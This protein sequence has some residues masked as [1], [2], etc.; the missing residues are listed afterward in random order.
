ML[1][2]TSPYWPIENNIKLR[3]NLVAP[4]L[5]GI[6][7]LRVPIDLCPKFSIVADHTLNGRMQVWDFKIIDKDL[8]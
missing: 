2:D 6:A 7:T 8:D 3:A 1:T 4:S 5:L